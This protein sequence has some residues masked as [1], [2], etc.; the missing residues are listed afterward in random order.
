MR[1]GRYHFSAVF[2]ETAQLPP[3]KGS[4]FRGAFGHALRQTLCISR[5]RD[6][7]ACL[8]AQRCLYARTFENRSQPAPEPTARTVAPPLPYVL[9]PEPSEKN[10]FDAGE[11]F[12]FD[13][14]LFG[15]CNDYLPYFVFA[16]EQMGQGGIGRRRGD[17][18]GRFGQ[19]QV[20][21][22]DQAIYQ[23]PGGQLV[24]G[25]HDESLSLPV[26]A[27]GGEGQLTLRLLTPL[28]LKFANHYQAEL[29]FHILVRAMLRRISSL[30]ENHGDGEPELDYRGLVQRAQAVPVQTSDLRWFDWTRYSNRQER[31]M[32]MGGMVG[33]VAY[34]GNLAPY[35]PLLELSRTL[36]LGKQ[37]SFGLGRIDYTW[38]P[39][40]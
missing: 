34:E 9:E 20:S 35:V 33:E 37:T 26:A 31:E 23:G 11:T 4:T 39:R 25:P 21:V 2:S 7:T 40:P 19:V 10:V 32:L 14:L 5:Q 13:L 16:V 38:Q 30:F 24:A 22:Q 6:C 8:L 3:Y 15:E 1:C 27:D 36:H 28:R 18:R 29:P 12:S 17:V